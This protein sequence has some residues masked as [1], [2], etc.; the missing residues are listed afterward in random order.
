M[1]DSW[2]VTEDSQQDV[3]EE[4]GTAATLKEDT[5]RWENDGKDDLADVAV[6]SLLAIGLVVYK[7]QWQAIRRSYAEAVRRT[8]TSSRSCCLLCDEGEV[9]YLAVKA[10]V[11]EL[12][13]Y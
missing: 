11:M 3:D 13:L 10:I 9:S 2:N 5:K 6:M 8:M 7:T 1:D 4:V 12:S